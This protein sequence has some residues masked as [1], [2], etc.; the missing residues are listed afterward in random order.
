VT[1][2]ACTWPERLTLFLPIGRDFGG[3]GAAGDGGADQI[4]LKDLP[5]ASKISFP[6]CAKN[7]FDAVKKEHHLRHEGRRQLQLYMKGTR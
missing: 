1:I 4:T 7:L 2:Y 3:P 6:L 5:G